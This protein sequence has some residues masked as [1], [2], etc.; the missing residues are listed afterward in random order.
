MLLAFEKYQ[1]KMELVDLSEEAKWGS[2]RRMKV[3]SGTIF[4]CKIKWGNKFKSKGVTPLSAAR[5]IVP[6]TGLQI[7]FNF[8]E[9]I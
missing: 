8:I 3:E 5:E 9:I 2:E 6:S 7:A 4:N 1:I